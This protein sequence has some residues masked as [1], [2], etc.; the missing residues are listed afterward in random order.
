MSKIL[1]T[2]D[3]GFIGQHVVKKL[4]ALGHTVIGVDCLDS[5]VHPPM[6]GDNECAYKIY[7]EPVSFHG[8][9]DDPDVVIHLAARVGVG[10]SMYE[11]DQYTKQN[12]YETAQMLQAMYGFP[13][14]RL[15]VASSMSV[16]GE[17]GLEPV[18]EDRPVDLRS[19]YALT[20]YDQEQMC[21]IWGKAYKVPTVAL[22]FF[23]TYG[24]GQSLNNPYTGVMAIFASRLLNG[25]PPVIYGDGSQSRDF[26]HVDDVANAVVHAAT[27]EID[28]GIY[29]VGTGD[30]T[31][32]NEIA[33]V[34]SCQLVGGDIVPIHAAERSGDIQH[35]VA[36]TFKLYK[37]GWKSQIA[38]RSGMKS[39]CDWLCDQPKPIDRFEQ[40]HKELVV[41]GL[42]T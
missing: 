24:P 3:R 39:Y 8:F 7:N 21:L 19:I 17:G 20:K 14:K 34:L 40:A 23:N 32:I 42:T 26:I 11:I 35:C 18:R 31:T 1:V 29:N 25:N 36:E 38:L 9:E 15:V 27:K 22:R 2:G 13:I 16:Y 12:S 6:E 30:R 33:E 4:R 28:S 41:H 5:Q 37:A 10:Q